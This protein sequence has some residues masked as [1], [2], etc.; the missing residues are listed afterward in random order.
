MNHKSIKKDKK[1]SENVPLA[2]FRGVCSY[3]YNI[4]FFPATASATALLYILRSRFYIH[5]HVI[6]LTI[7]IGRLCFAFSLVQ[8]SAVLQIRKQCKHLCSFLRYR[9]VSPNRNEDI[10]VACSVD[11]GRGVH[12]RE[13]GVGVVGQHNLPNM[14][15]PNGPTIARTTP[16]ASS[17]TP[18]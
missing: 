13:V 5:D 14:E 18:S 7:L 15:L 6:F 17:K 11:D 16:S 1:L 4:S 3:I 10:V 9:R 8:N 12:V 2:F